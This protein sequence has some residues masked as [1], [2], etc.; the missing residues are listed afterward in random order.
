M[1]IGLFY[2]KPD[3]VSKEKNYLLNS[4]HNSTKSQLIS[5]GELIWEISGYIYFSNYFL[6]KSVYYCWIHIRFKPGKEEIIMLK[7]YII[8][9]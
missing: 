9:L 7:N 2:N 1:N 6:L 4:T 8:T 5:F 3:F